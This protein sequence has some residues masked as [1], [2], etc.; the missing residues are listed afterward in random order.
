MD[1]IRNYHRASIKSGWTRVDML[2]ML[3][4][5][6]INGT[7]SCQIAHEAGADEA[8]RQHELAFRKTIMTIHAGL[9]PD[10]DEVAYNIARLLHFVMVKFDEK[11]FAAGK[12]VLQNIRNSFSQIAEEA[13]QL[14]NEGVIEP[15]PE[16]DAFES[17]A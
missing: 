4:D 10:E 12:K 17:I 13:N 6:A 8:F 9:K 11:D 16:H 1:Q 5:R 15:L 7:E 2:I 3:Y 14:E